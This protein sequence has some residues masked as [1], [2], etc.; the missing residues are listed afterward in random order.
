MKK[1]HE[2]NVVS[3]G[4]NSRADIPQ[5]V[6]EELTRVQLTGKSNVLPD[7]MQEPPP[8]EIGYSAMTVNAAPV[9]RPVPP[10]TVYWDNAAGAYKVAEPVV[11]A[12]NASEGAWTTVQVANRG[13]TFGDSDKVYLKLAEGKRAD[14]STKLEGELTKEASGDVLCVA[15]IS[16]SE[17]YISGAVVIYGRGAVLKGNTTDSVEVSGSVEIVSGADSNVKVKTYYEGTTPKM[18]IDVYY[19]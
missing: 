17:Q 11:Y 2:D 1:D 15:D 14:G 12:W 18:S 8:D 13:L 10:F 4:V 5:P 9:G 16:K 3:W 7:P 6:K 19:L